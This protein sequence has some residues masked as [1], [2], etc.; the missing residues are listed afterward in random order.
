MTQGHNDLL[1]AE[2]FANALVPSFYEKGE[3]PSANTVCRWCR[4]GKL[5]GA[6]KLGESTSAWIIPRSALYSF[7]KPKL[8]PPFRFPIDSDFDD[9]PARPEPAIQ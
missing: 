2:Q 4:E 9:K 3:A 8:G 7:H 1:S 6:F 5:A